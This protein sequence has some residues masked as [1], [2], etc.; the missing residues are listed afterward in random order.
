MSAGATGADDNPLTRDPFDVAVIG[1]GPGGI[2]AACAAARLGARTIVVDRRGFPG[3]VA[4][5]CCCPYLMGFAHG[6]RQIVGGI[7]DDLVRELDRMGHAA[8]IQEPSATP[9]PRPIGDRPLLGNVITSVEGV[10]VAA[11][12]LL[13]RASCERLLYAR[14]IGATVEDGRLT[15]AVVDAADGPMMI[16]A[17]AF[18]DATGDA[19]L[20]ARAGGHVT[21]GPVE[22]TMTKTILLRVGGVNGFHRP[23]VEEVFYRLVEQGKSPFPAQDRFM[24]FATLNPGEV[25]L[26]FTLTAGDGLSSAELTRMDGE[27]RE[28]ALVTV[29]WFRRH[30]P[31]FVDCFLVDTATELGVRAGRCIVGKETITCED[32][33]R[34][35]PVPEPVALGTRWY[36]GHGLDGFTSSWAKSNAGIRA[37]PWGALLSAS[38]GNVVAAGRA[39]SAQAR[40][41]DTFRLM[42]RCLAIGQAAGVTAALAARSEGDTNVVSYGAV[43]EALQGQGAILQ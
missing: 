31:S 29:D 24:G 40:V 10:R 30:I 5:A 15:A 36:G 42:S 25:L 17:K 16:R 6:G 21:A 9:E 23:Q 1:A 20:V 19:H 41:I 43:R 3:G 22:D 28:Q 8:F 2:G 26:N 12:R 33:D 35:V 37:V 27:L 7:A 38:Y 32:V 39:I 13:A 4:A 11:N 34:D 18:V 14:L